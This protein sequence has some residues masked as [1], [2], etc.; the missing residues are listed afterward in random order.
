LKIL[1]AEDQ[2]PTVLFLRRILERM[3]H[4]VA[5]A[6]D[7]VAAWREIQRGDATLLISDWVMPGLDGPELCRR[8][9]ALE[10]PGYLYVILLTSR[11]RHVDKLEGL[12]AGADDFLIKPPDPDEL[13]VRLEIAGRILAVHE[14]LARQNAQLAELA[15]VD[16]L[17]RVKNRR[18]FR[19]DLERHVGS[20]V[21]TG[22]PLSMIMIDVDHFKQYND[23]F[24]HTAGDELLRAV[25]SVL[26]GAVR[27]GDVLARYGGEEFAVLLPSTAADAARAVAE[28]LRA[29]LACYRWPLRPV[30]A[31]FGVATASPTSPGEAVTLVDHADEAMYRSKRNGRDRVTHHRDPAQPA[32]SPSPSPSDPV[33]SWTSPN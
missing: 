13:A 18:Q 32:P 9:R 20:A 30:T 19:A 16:E 3:G 2:A 33:A 10:R 14:R 11:D 31:S 5:V 25:A 17:T 26:R 1:I 4:E 28:R 22:L 21:R 15:T 6:N 24:G 27:D 12:R 8:V 29:A 7:G 23:R